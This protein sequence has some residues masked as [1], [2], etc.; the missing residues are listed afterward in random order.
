MRRVFSMSK[1]IMYIYRYTDITDQ[2]YDFKAVSTTIFHSHGIKKLLKNS[3][4]RQ[5]TDINYQSAMNL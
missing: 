4:N 3:N 5:F 1:N 2:L